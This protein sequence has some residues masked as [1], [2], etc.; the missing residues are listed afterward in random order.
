MHRIVGRFMLIAALALAVLGTPQRAEAA[1]ITVTPDNLQGWEIINIQPSNIPLSSFV[2][3]PGE[4][5]LGQGSYQVRLDGRASMVMLVRRDLES[6]KLTEIKTISFH[7]YR[8]GGNAAHDWYI[9]LFLSTDPNRPYA[10]C[11]VDFATPPGDQGIWQ[12]KPATDASIYN[13][14]WTVHHADTNLKECP[15][16]IDYDKNVSFEGILEAFKANPD[17]IF[18]PP[19]QFQP[20]IAFNTGFNGPNTHAG[21]ES[22]IDAIT[23][24]ETTWDFELSADM[25]VRLV[26][27]DSLT[28]WE[29]VPVNEDA[30]VSFGFVEGPG[31]PPLGKGSYRVQL[32]ERPSIMLI[33]NFGLVSTKL[34]EINTIS[35]H[36]YRSGENQRDWYLNLFVSSSGKDEADC[37]IDFAVDA[38][39]KNQW[40]FRDATNPQLFN[41]GWT[42]HHVEPRRCPITV[43][44]DQSKSF[45]EIKRLFEAY[46]DA[47]LKP[48]EPGGPVVSFNTGYNSQGTHAGH[49]AAIDAITINNVTWD[50][51]PS[52]K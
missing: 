50:F 12:F 15:V 39:E 17:T 8:S 23:I 44:Y 10:N 35:F 6:R 19:S 1:T 38:G 14:G 32:D 52:G 28:D 20:V 47:A 9:N 40:T 42:V 27:P 31:A 41:Y 46:P 4:P 3:G 43:G 7:T 29:L 22:A 37:R 25:I 2:E 5:P 21:H 18:R 49:D 45:S 33:M 34:S 24:N 30:M 36:T 16:T 48:R 26:S 51:E 13:Y 11:R